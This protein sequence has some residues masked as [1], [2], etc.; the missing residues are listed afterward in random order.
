MA[1][2]VFSQTADWLRTNKS[3]SENA[4]L[5]QVLKLRN[6]KT[7]ADEALIIT[8]IL[9]GLLTSFTAYCGWMYYHDTFSKTF[10][11]AMAVIFAAGLALAVEASKVYLMH[12]SLRSIFFGWM[13]RDGWEMASWFFVLLIASGAFYWSVDIS[14]EGMERLTSQVG[15]ERTKGEGLTAHVAAATAPIDLQ[16]KEAQEAQE[17][18]QITGTKRGRLT[19]DKTA[20]RLTILSADRQKAADK[21]TAEY[22]KVEGKREVKVEGWAAWVKKF[23][24]YMEAAAFLCLL[25][26]GT[27]ERKLYGENLKMIEAEDRKKADVD[28]A[29]R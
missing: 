29:F 1:E 24:G 8:K 11:P 3:K 4:K 16:I 21:A 12:L 19:A 5:N 26:V 28:A 9:L 6:G 15:E 23:G 25:A 2:N 27:F 7:N 22:E 14:T 18:A 10:D 17:R 13:F 20:D